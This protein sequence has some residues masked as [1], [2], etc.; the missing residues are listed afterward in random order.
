LTKLAGRIPT[1]HGLIE[2]AIEPDT[3]GTITI[4][5]GVEADVYF[6]DA[7]LRGGAFSSGTHAI[8]RGRLLRPTPL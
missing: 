6:D 1:P 5:A 7:D 3:G 2:V 4:P 8:R